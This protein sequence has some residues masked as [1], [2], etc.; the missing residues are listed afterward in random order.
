MYSPVRVFFFAVGLMK[1]QEETVGLF[2]RRCDRL[3][4]VS[5]EGEDQLNL[6]AIMMTALDGSLWEINLI[7]PLR[8]EHMNCLLIVRKGMNKHF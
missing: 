4:G 3:R 2:S 7:D 5:P 6:L 1:R 8:V